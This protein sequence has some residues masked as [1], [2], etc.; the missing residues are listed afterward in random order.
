MSLE[1]L[2]AELSADPLAR[3]YSSM[4]DQSVSDDLQSEYRTENKSIESSELLA[5]SAADGRLTRLQIAADDTAHPAHAIASAACLLISR[6]DTALDLAKPDR[7]EFLHALV[8]ASVLTDLDRDSL[9]A[10]SIEPVSR[11]AELGLGRCRPGEIAMAK[12]I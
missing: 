6:D 7:V 3:G 10:L 4:S 1:K 9:V 2:A 8:A 11:A 12:S 5:W